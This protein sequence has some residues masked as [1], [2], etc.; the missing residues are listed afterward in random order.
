MVVKFTEV[1]ETTNLHTKNATRKYSLREIFI[2]PGQVVCIRMDPGFKE[3]LFEGE[4][5]KGLDKRQEFSRIYLNRGQ[6]GLDIVVIGTPG[7]VEQRLN[8]DF[9][10]KHGLIKG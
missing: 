3:R 4:L 9:K 10:S 6:V 1:Y 8:H 5:P 7:Q 2:N